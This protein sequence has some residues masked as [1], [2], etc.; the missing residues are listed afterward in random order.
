M[1]RQILAELRKRQM[2]LDRAKD[3]M[4][5][6]PFCGSILKSV[7]KNGNGEVFEHDC[8]C[9]LYL[10]LDWVENSVETG[11]TN[12]D[13]RTLDA[14]YP[15][16]ENISQNRPNA[17]M[18]NQFYSKSCHN[19]KRPGVDSRD[20]NCVEDPP[21]QYKCKYCHHSLRTHFEFGQGQLYDLAKKNITWRYHNGQRVLFNDY[22]RAI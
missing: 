1:D 11:C 2:L 8:D 5:D 3:N 19:C 12:Y 20:P 18:D 21:Y 14:M 16:D 17:P 15:V 10:Q 4:E 9:E 13:D 7:G 6:C 22:S